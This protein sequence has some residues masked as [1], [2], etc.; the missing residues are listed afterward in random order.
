[1]SN[2]KVHYLDAAT[3]FEAWPHPA[4]LTQALRVPVSGTG[5]A[6]GAT[7]VGST[8]PSFRGN[9]LSSFNAG[10]ARP[11]A[12]LENKSAG[13]IKAQLTASGPRPESF[14]AIVRKL[15]I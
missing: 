6:G 7:W 10:H 2:M 13:L 4:K 3:P 5:V 11:S 8:N 15:R 1:M 14:L 9:A 12:G